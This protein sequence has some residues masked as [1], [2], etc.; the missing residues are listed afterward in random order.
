MEKVLGEAVE[1]ATIEN[2]LKGFNKIV[3]ESHTIIGKT[4][5]VTVISK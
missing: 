3:S 4:I 2:S 5:F 1:K